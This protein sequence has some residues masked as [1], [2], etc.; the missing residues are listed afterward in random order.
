MVRRTAFEFFS[1]FLSE[2]GADEIW[3]ACSGGLDSMALLRL[4]QEFVASRRVGLGVIHLNHN[5]RPEAAADER[6]VA[7]YALKAELPLVL[8]QVRDLKNEVSNSNHSLETLARNY[9][10]AFFQRLLKSRPQAVLLTAHNASD[11]VETIMMNLMRG[12]GLRGIKGIPG[13]RGRIGRP[14]LEVTRARLAEYVSENRISFREDPS[15]L[16]LAFSRNRIRHELLP[17]IRKLG[18][19]GVEERIAG[20]GLRLASDL[21]IIDRRLDDLWRETEFI[22]SGIAISRRLL[23]ESEAELRPHFIARMVRRAGAVKQV[24]APILSRLAELV[25]DVG[26]QQSSHYDLGTG[27]FFKTSADLVVVGRENCLGEPPFS[28]PEYQIVLPDY[29][30]FHL[31]HG[32]GDLEL[33][34]VKAPAVKNFPEVIFERNTTKSKYREFIAVDKLQFPLLLRNRRPGDR[35]QPLGLDG[36]SCKLK[37]F[38]NAHSLSPYQ[39]SAIPLLWNGDGALIWVVGEHLDHRFKVSSESKKLAALTF[40]PG[41]CPEVHPTGNG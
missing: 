32:L 37:K 24:S 21:K 23:Q 27:L 3:I 8:G 9:R 6:F 34:P 5:L 18:G 19:T 4:A 26:R 12:S 28:V 40:L 20:A 38:F 25:G 17:V 30:F 13:R 22:N 7:D 29:G 2:T 14:L 10:Y 39:R 16:S 1:R 36:K 35:F 41:S 33:Q 31:P 11:Q 15:N